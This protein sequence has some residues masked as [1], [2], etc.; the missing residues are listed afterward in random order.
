MIVGNIRLRIGN[1]SM[2]FLYVLG[3]FLVLVA[4]VVVASVRS[5]VHDDDKCEANTGNK[6]VIPFRINM[7]FE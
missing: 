4:S 1:L 6:E 5:L 3:V 2:K 7:C